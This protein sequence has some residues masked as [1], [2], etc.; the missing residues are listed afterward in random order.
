MNAT[1]NHHDSLRGK[2]TGAVKLDPRISVTWKADRPFHPPIQAAGKGKG[3]QADSLSLRRP[4]VKI[5]VVYQHDVNRDRAQ[6]MQEELARRLGQSFNFLVSWWKL[7]SLWHPKMLQV[8]ADHIAKADIIVFSLLS[9]GE[10]PQTIKKWIEKSLL[11]NKTHRAFLLALLETGGRIAPW[12][13]PAET[14]LSQLSSKAGADCLVYSD[15]LAVARDI[16]NNRGG[17]VLEIR[18][19]D[20]VHFPVCLRRAK[21]GLARA[22]H[23][24]GWIMRQERKGPRWQKSC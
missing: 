19:F 4:F 9:G 14:Y 13:S 5:F 18:K 24:S 22:P 21:P 3:Q 1:F 7:R 15:S 17:S 20:S 23:G 16:R 2:A 8:A 11:N 10:L 12:L 6:L